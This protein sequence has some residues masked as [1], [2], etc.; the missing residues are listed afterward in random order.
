MLKAPRLFVAVSVTVALSVAA[1]AAPAGAASKQPTVKQ[2]ANSVCGTVNDWISSIQ[3]TISSATDASSL[4]AAINTATKGI[5]KAT[6]TLVDDLDNLDRPDTPQAKKAQQSVEKL[7]N[8]LQQT[9]H[10]IEDTLSSS[11]KGGGDIAST[12]E[13]VGNSVQAAIQQI[14]TTTK[15]L[16]GLDADGQLKTAFQTAP[17][18]KTL[19]KDLSSVV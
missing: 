6:N 16:K 17:E 12:I 10:D 1:V 5:K 7:S 4:E 3:D 2:W 19:K 14:Q 18:C 11:G 13:D 15:T 8:Q 9:V